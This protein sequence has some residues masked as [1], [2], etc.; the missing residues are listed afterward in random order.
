MGLLG[1]MFG[2]LRMKD[3]VQ[4]SAQ[5][6]SCSG[7]R[8][9]RLMQ[10]CRLQLVVRGDGVPA[11]AIEHHGLVHR[12]RWPSPGMTLPVTVDRANPNRVR[13]RWREVE[14]SRDRAL[15]SAAELTSARRPDSEEPGGGGTPPR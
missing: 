8:G 9:D 12:E 10:N 4:G 7:H 14:S 3:P 2:G 15:R 13:V 6:V 5:V 1:H 11:K